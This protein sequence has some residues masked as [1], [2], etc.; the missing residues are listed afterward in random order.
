M[1]I[2]S[3]FIL[4]KTKKSADSLNP[5]LAFNNIM[6][7]F[8]C[9]EYTFVAAE[10]LIFLFSSFFDRNGLKKKNKKKDVKSYVS[11]VMNITQTVFI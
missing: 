11:A 1:C 7:C 2:A 3:L 8:S 9:Q 4:K 10:R 6:Y 5:K